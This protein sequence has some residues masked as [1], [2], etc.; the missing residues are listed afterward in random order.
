MKSEVLLE[1]IFWLNPW[2]GPQ[3]IFFEKN[4]SWRK[5]LKHI[6]IDSVLNADFKYVINFDCSHAFFDWIVSDANKLCK[7]VNINIL[8]TSESRLIENSFTLLPND[9]SHN[10]ASSKPWIKQNS[11]PHRNG[12][13]PHSP[14]VHGKKLMPIFRP[15]RDGL[16]FQ[17]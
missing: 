4:K 17:I 13:Y 3:L 9:S 12:S 5:Y 15:F 10:S 8:T 7:K 2:G 6:W 11:R 14:L 1:L 16:K